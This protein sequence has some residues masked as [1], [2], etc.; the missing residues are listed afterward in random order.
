MS[1]AGAFKSGL[2]CMEILSA[3][4]GPFLTFTT[5]KVSGEPQEG[6]VSREKV[7]THTGRV[8]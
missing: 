8:G 4:D 5:V 1:S 7:I 6:R 2:S 3:L